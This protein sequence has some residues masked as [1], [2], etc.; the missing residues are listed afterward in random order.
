M[1]KVQYSVY[2]RETGTAG[3]KAKNDAYD[4][5]FSSWI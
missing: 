1:R 4:I 2:R 5:A 3:G